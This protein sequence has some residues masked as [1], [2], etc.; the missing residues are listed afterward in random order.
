MREALSDRDEHVQAAA[1]RAVGQLAQQGPAVVAELLS[2]GV[3]GRLIHM[4]AGSDVMEEVERARPLLIDN[5]DSAEALANVLEGA[6]RPVAEDVLKQLT[7]VLKDNKAEQTRFVQG[8]GLAILQRLDPSL[9]PPVQNV[10]SIFDNT[11]TLDWYAGAS[12]PKRRD[13]G[14]EAG[15]REA[16]QPRSLIVTL[17]RAKDLVNMDKNARAGRVRSLLQ[18]QGRGRQG[19]A[20]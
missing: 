12:G 8:G 7:R 13:A 5:A 11:A 3:L 9:D 20:E 18:A 14:R 2:V 15:G 16:G 19:A 4:R 17:L 1:A 6:P 10:R